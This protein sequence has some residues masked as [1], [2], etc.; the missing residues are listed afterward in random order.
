[1]LM[2][3]ECFITLSSHLLQAYKVAGVNVYKK[4]K[5]VG[6]HVYVNTVKP[7]MKVT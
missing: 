7:V 4:K 2:H 1:M 5:V 3:D 6:V